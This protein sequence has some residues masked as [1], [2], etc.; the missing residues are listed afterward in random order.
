MNYEMIF[1]SKLPLIERRSTNGA[2]SSTIERAKLVGPAD[3]IRDLPCAID[4]SSLCL[5]VERRPDDGSPFQISF[6]RCRGRVD[7]G[8]GWTRRR[9]EDCA[10][11]CRRSLTLVTTKSR[12]QIRNS[13]IGECS[14]RFNQFSVLIP[15]RMDEWRC[16]CRSP[17]VCVLV[18][19][20]NGWAG[21]GGG[22]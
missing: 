13:A 12:T 7:G 3:S 8:R 10:Y 15:Y 5:V 1:N 17:G 11:S 16:E 6:R 22:R 19:L 21:A 4:L 18:L 14:C 2:I 20:A 9:L